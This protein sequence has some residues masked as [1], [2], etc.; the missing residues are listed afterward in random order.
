MKS[1]K[2]WKKKSLIHEQQQSSVRH[3]SSD[4]IDM[5]LPSSVKE[6]INNTH[7]KPELPSYMLNSLS[8]LKDHGFDSDSNAPAFYWS[9][10]QLPGSGVRNLTAKAFSLPTQQVTNEEARFS[11]TISSLLIQLT[12][13]QR[14]L[15][16]ECMLQAANSKHPKLSIFGN[17]CVPTSEDNFQKFYLS[18]PK[19]VVPNLPHLIPVATADGTHA[20]VGLS[21]LLTN[22]LAK[23]TLFDKFY[24]ESNVQFLPKDIP[25]LST[26]PSA[27]K[28]FFDLEEDDDD[29]YILYLWYKEWSDDF[30]PNN[31]KVSRNQVW[32]NT[33][34]I[35]PN[36]GETQGR[37]S[38]FMSLS[39]KGE[40]HSERE[41][42]F[43][44]ELN[45]LSNE[46]KMF[47][48][49]GLKHIIKAKM[50]KLLLCV[51]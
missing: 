31:T 8:E 18:G 28:L 48:H 44:N 6:S 26:A 22:E 12:E 24:F 19:A 43:H 47:Y 13:S 21:D 32:I 10:H 34:T 36:K 39:C 23:A 38:Y 49:G 42:L 17:T 37:N 45:V 27:Y 11:L 35:C 16:A 3:S 9:K 50:G 29:R 14:E 15:F 20:F 46:G 33:F 25:T 5:G 1:M 30:D 7:P 4:N 41:M 51:D 40:D 2:Y